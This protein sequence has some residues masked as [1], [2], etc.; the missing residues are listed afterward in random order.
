MD[1]AEHI[2]RSLVYPFQRKHALL[3]FSACHL[4]L[5]QLGSS[6]FNGHSPPIHTDSPTSPEPKL[7]ERREESWARVVV[8]RVDVV[9][10]VLQPL[11]QL[12]HNSMGDTT[13]FIK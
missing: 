3:H 1:G 8:V 4:S 7:A 11:N 13:A 6:D 2:H 9:S 10:L 12:E 5:L